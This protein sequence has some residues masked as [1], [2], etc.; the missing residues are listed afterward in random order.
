MFRFTLFRSKN[1]FS[2]SLTLKSKIHKTAK[3]NWQNRTFQGGLSPAWRLYGE[4]LLWSSSYHKE[5]NFPKKTKGMLLPK[6]NSIKREMVWIFI[7][8]R[9]PPHNTQ[10]GGLTKIVGFFP[11]IFPLPFSIN[12]KLQCFRHI[13]T[14]F[15]CTYNKQVRHFW[16]C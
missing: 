4:Q 7:R 13:L 5:V 9:P 2:T 10:K 11:D 12:E 8:P 6:Q 1:L 15:H 14:A 3:T 16:Y